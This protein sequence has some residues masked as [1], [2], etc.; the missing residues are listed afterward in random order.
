MY[1]ICK[2]AGF[3]RAGHK[4]WWRMVAMELGVVTW[5]S[6]VLLLS[7]LRFTS[8][9]NKRPGDPGYMKVHGY[10]CC[11]NNL[12]ANDKMLNKNLATSFASTLPLVLLPA[13]QTSLLSLDAI[14]K[15]FYFAYLGNCRMQCF[16]IINLNSFI[17][18]KQYHWTAPLNI[19][20]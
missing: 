5:E 20:I 16:Y 18:Y 15:S 19:L 10:H 1:K 9:P 4:E 2:H 6:T 7:L 14:S 11:A 8:L 3:R 17:N 13:I 12:I